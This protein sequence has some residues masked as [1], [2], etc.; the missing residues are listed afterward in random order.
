MIPFSQNERINSRRS[1]Q[2]AWNIAS[3]ALSIWVT[4]KF[5]PL[6][7][8]RLGQT[9]TSLSGVAF[10]SGFS[11]ALTIG[12]LFPK[13]PPE[14]QNNQ[15]SNLETSQYLLQTLPQS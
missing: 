8:S 9:M 7:A 1:Y 2:I 11:L 6:L 14:N 10:G 3:F 13:K 12:S 4:Y 5:T 15:K